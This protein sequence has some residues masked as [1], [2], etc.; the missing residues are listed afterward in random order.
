MEKKF[1]YSGWFEQALCGIK[2]IRDPH[3]TRPET[4]DL[5]WRDVAS[6][7]VF[8]FV[9]TD[10]R[11]YH[12]VSVAANNI[13]VS[14]LCFMITQLLKEYEYSIQEVAVKN[15]DGL[16]KAHLYIHDKKNNTLLL[17][18]D[19]EKYP[20]WKSN[21]KEPQEVQSIMDDCG[22]KTCKYIYFVMDN[23]Y[24]QI[25]GHNDDADDP[26]RGYNAYSLK[27]FFEEYFG[28][29]EYGRFS[30]EL[31]L[32]VESVRNC[33]GYNTVKT[34]TPGSLINFRKV[35]ENE[36]LKYP[37]DELLNVQVKNYTLE[38]TELNKLKDQFFKDKTFQGLLGNKDY[39]ESL[40]TAEWLFDSMKKAQAIDLTIIG[41]GYFKAVEQLLY[42][43]I[44]LHKNE[45]RQIKKDY[46]RRDSLAT[47]ELNDANIDDEAIDTTIGSMAVFY[48]DNL[49]MLR[50]DLT[51]RTRKYVLETIFEF[52]DLRNR[53]FHKDNIYDWGKIEFIRKSTFE[54][55][56]LLLAAKT[57][58][59]D[60]NTILGFPK[61]ITSDY[62][63]LCEYIHYHH[64]ELFYLDFGR[65]NEDLAFGYYDARSKVLDDK[66]VGY[67]GVYFKELGEG[68]RIV[69]FSED[70]LP[71][72][73]SLGKFVFGYSDKIDITPVKVKP[74]FENSKFVGPSIAEEEKLDY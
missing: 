69:R 18:K 74:I 37:Y 15:T 51:C 48:R 73:I 2:K 34:L 9:E 13:S 35:T 72:K 53:Y 49:D 22:A 19:I 17:F 10:L 67:T 63:K 38:P 26:G 8:D 25:I 3:S 28:V 46:S 6:Q 65:E 23:A 4:A 27:W 33:I 5:R 59:E 24:L 44:C 12:N 54:L 21:E 50:N 71:S 1:N 40:V 55:L 56:F 41:M 60:N 16:A 66:Y 61:E 47:V 64:G 39:A 68:G 57:I 70:K 7:V 58:T 52:K 36:I 20:L 43:L 30:K 42:E 29:E 32:Y 11:K 31:E 45:G 62:Y 14:C